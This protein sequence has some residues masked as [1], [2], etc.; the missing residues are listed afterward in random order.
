M[1]T[2]R[3]AISILVVAIAAPLLSPAGTRAEDA[4]TPQINYISADAVYLNAGKYAGL[5]IGSVVE[6][7]REGR[8][9][10]VLEV[11]HISSHSASC[12]IIEKTDELRVGDVVAFEV[13]AKEPAD[14]LAPAMPVLAVGVPTAPAVRRTTNIVNGYLELQGVWQEDRNGSGVSSV[15]PALVARIAVKN[16]GGTGAEL[17]VRDRIRLYHRHRALGAGVDEDEWYHRLTEFAF[18]YERPDAGVQWGAGRLVPPYMIGTGHIDGGYVAVRVNE[19]L[20]VGAAG[21]F[22]PDPE[23]IGFAGDRG[24]AGG[25]LAFE[26]R[27]PSGWRFASSAALAGS[28]V[29]GTVSREL[30]Y[31]Q[32][33]LS[34][35]RRFS[36]FQSVE[37]DLNRDW[38]RD[39][40]GEGVTF[41]NFY[42]SAEA[43]AS[44]YAVVDFTYDSRKNVRVYET[45]STP[46]SLFDD[47]VYEGFGGGLMLR[48]PRGITLGGRGGIRYRENDRTNRYFSLQARVMQLPWRGH[49][50]WARYAFAQTRGVNGHRPALS[51]RLP[52]GKGL[53]VDATA[54]GYLYEH[55]TRWTK[56]FYAEGG[57]HYT[58]GRY[59]TS[60]SYRQ[61]FGGGLESLLF[62]GELGLRL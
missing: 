47:G 60:A 53:H 31:W 62:F 38:R 44:R 27:V 18:L 39:V 16:I 34:L 55:G 40:S 8:K 49:S 6:V 54:G 28:Y 20:R 3:H 35:A 21:G 17:R 14:T 22:E 57:A 36:I 32:N 2:M 45:M 61:Y 13:P 30:V 12:R 25:F 9:I 56:R 19:Y 5:A 4:Q 51:Y 10:A 52:V 43:E 11:V 42:I 48:F 50:V 29:S 1:N 15:Q 58:F 24:K 41:S 7:W 59:F 23:D 46:D 33:A 26:S 37:F